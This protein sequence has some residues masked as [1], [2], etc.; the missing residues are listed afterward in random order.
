M[1]SKTIKLSS[2]SKHSKGADQREEGGRAPVTREAV[3]EDLRLQIRGTWQ[4]MRILGASNEVLS[5]FLGADASGGDLY[6][7]SDLIDL[8]RFSITKLVTK[9]YDFAFQVGAKAHRFD[10]GDIDFLDMRVFRHGSPRWEGFGGQGDLPL[11]LEDSALSITLDTAEARMRILW[12]N[13]L[14]IRHL[15]RLGGMNLAAARTALSK[16]GI[17]TLPHRNEDG[18]GE[19]AYE[20]AI[21]WLNARRGFVPT[22]V[23]TPTDAEFT[24]DI[25]RLLKDVGFE[26]ELGSHISGAS[27]VKTAQRAKIDADWLLEFAS[28]RRVALDVGA[29]TRL[30]EDLHV[31]TPSF[32]ARGVELIMRR[33][34]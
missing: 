15:A 8:D 22:P 13:N 34:G 12:Q 18:Y 2:P 1:K 24:D 19:V 31:E 3:M 23:P 5:A 26:A 30:A 28:G 17:R 6:T 20:D 29:L 16:A 27:L 10:M 14:S 7:V 4:Q 21:R 9:A 32:V 25:V 33:N 11:A